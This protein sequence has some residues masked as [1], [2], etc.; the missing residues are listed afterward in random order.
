[1]Y[2]VYNMCV[3]VLHVSLFLHA[4][5]PLKSVLFMTYKR[6]TGKCCTLAPEWQ[7]DKSAPFL[8]MFQGLINL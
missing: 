5:V 7:L 2:C 8:F 4:S 3:C 6:C 1:M